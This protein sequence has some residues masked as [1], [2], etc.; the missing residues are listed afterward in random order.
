MTVLKKCRKCAVKTFLV[1]NIHN[2]TLWISSIAGYLCK[3]TPAIIK[4]S[5]YY[6]KKN[7]W[8]FGCEKKDLKIIFCF[9]TNGE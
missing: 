6:S 5:L 8:S 2:P 9:N 1:L 4:E 3:V 7:C